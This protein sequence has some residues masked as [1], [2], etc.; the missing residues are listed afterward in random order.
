MKIYIQ[1]LCL[2]LMLA[3]VSCDK[4]QRFE[5]NLDGTWELRHVK[6]GQIPNVSPDYPPGN[7]RI[8]KFE[9]NTFQIIRDGSVV[10]SGTFVI[11][12]DVKEIDG[13]KFR[14]KIDFDLNTQ[15]DLYSN[16]SR[17]KLI[18][19]TGSIASDGTTSTYERL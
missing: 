19:A 2:I 16:V 8:I 11:I 9:G 14:Y 17:K 6:G 5:N 1:S 10:Q 13:V 15:A 4:D 18:V 12:N 3:L 7:G